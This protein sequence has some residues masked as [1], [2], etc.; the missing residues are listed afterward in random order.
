[1]IASITFA[2]FAWEWGTK[3]R[4]YDD[5]GPF[6]LSNVMLHLSFAADWEM[7]IIAGLLAWS[8]GLG[9]YHA[10]SVGLLVFFTWKF[11][12]NGGRSAFSWNRVTS[13]LSKLD[14][15]ETVLIAGILERGV[16]AM[17]NG[18]RRRY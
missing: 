4:K 9:V 17:A 1:V 6:K 3:P 14:V 10:S 13:A 11:G 16:G 2:Y 15:W 5:R 18:R 12:T 7:M 8:L